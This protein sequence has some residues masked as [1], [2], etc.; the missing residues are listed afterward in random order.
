VIAF[1]ITNP[2]DYHHQP[3]RPRPS[4]SGVVGGRAARPPW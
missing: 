4:R 2:P 3:A 1:I